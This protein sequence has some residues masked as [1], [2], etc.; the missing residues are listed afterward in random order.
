M[1]RSK[2][3][4]P[5]PAGSPEYLV[6]SQFRDELLA[7]TNDRGR[8]TINNIWLV[9]DEMFRAGDPI[10]VAEV[11]RRLH[12]RFEGPKAQSIRDQPERLKRLVDLCAQ[13]GPRPKPLGTREEEGILGEIS[14]QTVRARIRLVLDERDRLKR[15]LTALRKVFGRLSPIKTLT[16]E[17]CYGSA[18]ESEHDRSEDGHLVSLNTFTSD[19]KAAIRKFLSPGFLQDEGFRIDDRLGLLSDESGRSILPPAFIRALR[20]IVGFSE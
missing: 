9:C 10:S 7:T 8:R 17:Q 2:E 1:P 13:V 5:E 14:D 19:E 12:A 4:T 20:K 11:G 16:V 3:P 6:A 18:N 15:E